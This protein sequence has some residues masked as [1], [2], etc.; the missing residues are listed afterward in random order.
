MSF[1]GELKINKVSFIV[2]NA[3]N[4]MFISIFQ[5]MSKPEIS[6]YLDNYDKKTN[7]GRCKSCEKNIIWSRIS[8]SSHKRASCPSAS[9]DEK[10]KF[11]KRKLPEVLNESIENVA[12]AAQKSSNLHWNDEQ[13][14]EANTKLANFFFRTGI[15][16]RLI[17]SEQI[18]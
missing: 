13:T 1:V 12:P 7:R 6:N 18:L 17:D 14:K 10:R 2:S 8:L 11:A 5:K 9:E 16:L 3:T 15:S 4:V